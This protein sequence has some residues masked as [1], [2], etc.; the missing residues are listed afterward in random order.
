M[1]ALDVLPSSDVEVLSRKLPLCDVELGVAD[2]RV[3]GSAGSSVM[4]M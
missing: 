2:V 1:R 4:K 3:R